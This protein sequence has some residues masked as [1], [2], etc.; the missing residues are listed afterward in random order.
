MVILSRTVPSLQKIEGLEFLNKVWNMKGL[1]YE[2]SK[3]D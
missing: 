2:I 3:T 1:D